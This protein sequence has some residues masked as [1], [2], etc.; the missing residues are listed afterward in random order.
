MPT[1]PRARQVREAVLAEMKSF[2]R[3]VPSVPAGEIKRDYHW[4]QRRG[5]PPRQR[6]EMVL[7]WIVYQRGIDEAA[8][9]ILAAAVGT[10]ICPKPTCSKRYKVLQVGKSVINLVHGFTRPH[11]MTKRP[12]KVRFTEESVRVKQ[13]LVKMLDNVYWI[14][15]KDHV[16]ESV[17]NE[18]RELSDLRRRWLARKGTKQAWTS[19]QWRNTVAE[20]KSG[21]WAAE[22]VV[23]QAEKLAEQRD[24]DARQAAAVLKPEWCLG[25]WKYRNRKVL[26]KHLGPH[27]QELRPTTTVDDQQEHE[28]KEGD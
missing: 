6:A 5:M 24:R 18:V 7:A 13:E 14:W 16:K 25:C 26:K 3:G 9:A 19:E 12:E 2:L 21:E 27:D 20:I 8:R 17:E 23:E 28:Q 1:T 15:V 10:D 22:R 4:N 11:C